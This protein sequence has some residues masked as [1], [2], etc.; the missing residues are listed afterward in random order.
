[1]AAQPTWSGNKV[2]SRRDMYV[3]GATSR[4]AISK[5]LRKQDL[6]VAVGSTITSRRNDDG[7]MSRGSAAMGGS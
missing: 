7:R 2:T 4:N 1:M 5:L 6:G 3:V